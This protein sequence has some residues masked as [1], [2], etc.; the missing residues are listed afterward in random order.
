M[1]SCL[2]STNYW[3]ISRIHLA[4][5]TCR[6]STISLPVWLRHNACIYFVNGEILSPIYAGLYLKASYF[7]PILT[8]I[9]FSQ[10]ILVKFPIGNLTNTYAVE[11]AL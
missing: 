11:A 7:Y 3:Q 9:I 10:Q 8:R 4:P 1:I 6:W 5:V 2:C